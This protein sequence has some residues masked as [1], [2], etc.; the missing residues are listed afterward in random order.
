LY[1]T[2]DQIR[3]EYSGAIIVQ[4]TSPYF[5]DGSG[6]LAAIAD[7]SLEEGSVVAVGDKLQT[8]TN[9]FLADTP[10]DPVFDPLKTVS[11]AVSSTVSQVAGAAQA[12]T[13]AAAG[14]MEDAA[15][16]LAGGVEE[17]TNG[18]QELIS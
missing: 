17:V 12:A 2:E 4:P 6:A 16:V 1:G 13:E 3:S 7:G 14:A 18:L 5:S 11:D 15:G 9:G 8:V 10:D